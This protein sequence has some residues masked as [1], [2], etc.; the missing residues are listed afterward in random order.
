MIETK[1]GSMGGGGVVLVA[2]RGLTGLIYEIT[3]ERDRMIF[4][5]L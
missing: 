2:C 1:Y 4:I 5:L 3:S